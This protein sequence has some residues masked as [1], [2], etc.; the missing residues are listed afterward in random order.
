MT[1]K[2]QCGFFSRLSPIIGTN[3][4]LGEYV[5]AVAHEVINDQETYGIPGFPRREDITPMT[6]TVVTPIITPPHFFFFR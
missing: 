1:K 5:E 6:E 2:S 3:D 4:I